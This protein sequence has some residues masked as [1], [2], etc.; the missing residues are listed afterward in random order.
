MQLQPMAKITCECGARL[1]LPPLKGKRFRCRNCQTIHESPYRTA[2]ELEPV[3]EERGL[4]KM[5][6]RRRSRLGLARGRKR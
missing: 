6:P 1:K 2:S 5:A 4:K 3:E